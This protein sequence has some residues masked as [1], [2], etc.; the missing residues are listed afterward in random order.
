[1]KVCLRE[2]KYFWNYVKPF[3]LGYTN[4]SNYAYRHKTY[5]VHMLL[6]PEWIKKKLCLSEYFH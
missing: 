4:I 5:K 2:A 1:M 3:A 6:S